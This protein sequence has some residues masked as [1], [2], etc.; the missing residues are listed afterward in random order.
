MKTDLGCLVAITTWYSAYYD[1]WLRGQFV[2]KIRE[3]HAQYGMAVPNMNI[4]IPVNCLF[5]G[6]VVRINPHELHCID[7]EFI[8]ELYVGGLKKRDKYKWVARG[9]CE[10]LIRGI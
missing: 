5:P 6:P 3:L 8:P 1:I 2:W 7:P 10:L 9:L 4:Q